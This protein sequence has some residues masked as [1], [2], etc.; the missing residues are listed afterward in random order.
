[1]IILSIKRRKRYACFAP[2]MKTAALRCRLQSPPLGTSYFSINVGAVCAIVKPLKRTFRT[3]SVALPL[4][5]T[6]LAVQNRRV[7]CSIF[8]ASVPS[9]S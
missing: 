8:H 7:G 5:S 3:G 6:T 1:M 9:L 4:I 2:S